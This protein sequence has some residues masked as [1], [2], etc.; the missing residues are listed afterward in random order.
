MV[1]DQT[2]CKKFPV[3]IDGAYRVP[4]ISAKDMACQL[5]DTVFIFQSA[6]LVVRVKTVSTDV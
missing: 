6:L 5:T 4:S 3:A 2:V 1:G